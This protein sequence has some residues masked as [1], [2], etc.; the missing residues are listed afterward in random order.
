MNAGH[1]RPQVGQ[2]SAA[3]ADEVMGMLEA[4]LADAFYDINIEACS[5]VLALVGARAVQ[6][7]GGRVRYITGGGGLL[8]LIGADC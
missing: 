3:Y 8:T 6:R 1:R 2:A 7:G 4:A 5:C